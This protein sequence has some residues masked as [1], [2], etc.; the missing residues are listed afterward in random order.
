VEGNID[1][2]SQRSEE[3]HILVTMQRLH[4]MDL[5]GLILSQSEEEWVHFMVPMRHD[6][7]R[8]CVTVVL[9]QYDNP[10]PLRLERLEQP[11]RQNRRFTSR[12]THYSPLVPK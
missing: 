5:S 2:T 8:H 1:D 4:E 10:E 3:Q 11:L 12:E 9:P 7:R 6:P